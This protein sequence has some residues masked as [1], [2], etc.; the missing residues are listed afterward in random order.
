M[1]IVNLE[2]KYIQYFSGLHW[3]YTQAYVRTKIARVFYYSQTSEIWVISFGGCLELEF[4][5]ISEL[6]YL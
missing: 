1:L 6:H 2:M 3:A 4:I 5:W